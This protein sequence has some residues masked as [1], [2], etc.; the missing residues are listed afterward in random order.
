MATRDQTRRWAVQVPD[1]LW[2][3]LAAG[4]LLIVI[5]F[6]GVLTNQPLLFPSLGPTAFLQA[7]DPQLR[8]ARFYN[9]VV[10][11]FIGLGSGILAVLLLHANH[12][13]S[14]MGTGHLAP[15]RVFAAA[16]AV[17]MTIAIGLI[18]HASHPPASATTLLVAL[19]GF[20]LNWQTML[21]IVT[22]VLLIGILGEVLRRFR[23]G[24][25][26]APGPE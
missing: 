23:L 22:G 24:K 19:G 26:P 8:T 6:F 12:V 14:A 16:L 2:G 4:S 3:P 1:I 11:H 20:K 7:E 17:A 9:T 25:L 21:I 18:L 15:E 13:P 10:G 5:G